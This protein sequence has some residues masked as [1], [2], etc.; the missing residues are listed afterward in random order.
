MWKYVSCPYLLKFTGVFYH[1]DMPAIVT[2]WM[3]HGNI[4]EYLGK[5]PDA[6]RLRLVSLNLSSAPDI[7]TPQLIVIS[8]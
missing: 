7:L 6:N 1:N 4:T 8:F 2:P 3:S 5:H